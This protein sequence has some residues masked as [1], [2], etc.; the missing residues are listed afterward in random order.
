MADPNETPSMEIVVTNSPSLTKSAQDFLEGGQLYDK[1]LGIIPAKT[2]ALPTS[3]ASNETDFTYV[4]S[5][6]EPM[7]SANKKLRNYSPFTMRVM[8]PLL[9]LD[10]PDLL[11][12]TEKGRVNMGL[13]DSAISNN[14]NFNNFIN[15]YPFKC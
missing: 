1:G 3:G 11:T 12:G 8:P 6:A 5:S 7:L 15:N 4:D 14:S 13:Y 9:Y 10:N 2:F